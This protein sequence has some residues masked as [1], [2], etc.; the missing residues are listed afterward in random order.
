MN[1]DI[2]SIRINLYR[3]PYSGVYPNLYILIRDDLLYRADSHA[4]VSFNPTLCTQAQMYA[5][6]NLVM[7]SCIIVVQHLVALCSQ[8]IYCLQSFFAMWTFR[9]LSSKHI[10]IL[11]ADV[12]A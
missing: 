9:L 5:S 3:R 1:R 10:S 2:Q 6:Y 4:R 7:S 11:K 8:V 12:P